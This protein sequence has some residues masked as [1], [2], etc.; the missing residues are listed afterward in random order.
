MKSRIE[1]NPRCSLVGDELFKAL[2]RVEGLEWFAVETALNGDTT[3]QFR[4][5]GMID[6]VKVSAASIL[7]APNESVT[8]Q[9]IV[10]TVELKIA[11]AVLQGLP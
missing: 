3:V 4:Y 11:N 6:E 5:H 1:M 10:N 7:D 2:N 9:A 8:I